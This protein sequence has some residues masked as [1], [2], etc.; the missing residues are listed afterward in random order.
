MSLGDTEFLDSMTLY[1]VPVVFHV[2]YHDD[3]ENIPDTQ[4]ISRIDSLNKDLRN[5]NLD[6]VIFD[7]Y[8]R[9]KAL[10]FDAK[11]IGFQVSSYLIPRLYY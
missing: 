2:V 9:E 7:K 5:L 3:I 11:I 4:I 1:T 8:P 6:N 10:A